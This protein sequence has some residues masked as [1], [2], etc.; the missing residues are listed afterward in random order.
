M[1]PDISAAEL[2]MRRYCAPSIVDMFDS[3]K[4]A[5][6]KE[7]LLLAL[8]TTQRDILLER[9]MDNTRGNGILTR[10]AGA[11]QLP[12]ETR[13][14]KS[15]PLVRAFLEM[16][17][18]AKLLCDE[19]NLDVCR[20][21]MSCWGV[22]S[23]T[24]QQ[25]NERVLW[26]K[27]SCLRSSNRTD[28]IALSRTNNTVIKRGSALP[29]W[30][31]LRRIGVS[32][33][34]LFA[35]AKECYLEGE[36][37]GEAIL[38]VLGGTVLIQDSDGGLVVVHFYNVLPAGIRGMEADPLLKAKF[39]MGASMRVAEPFLK[40]LREGSIG[41]RVDDPS[42][43]AVLP[44]NKLSL[45][46][47][48]AQLIGLKERGK[49]FFAAKKFDAAIDMY[50]AA[51]RE[52]GD[53]IPT[54]LSNRSQAFIRLEHWSS[55]LC[56]AAAS[57]T[58]RPSCKKTFARYRLARANLTEDGFRGH[59]AFGKLIG[60]VLT[61]T[62]S[63]DALVDR[64]N[65]NALKQAGNTAFQ[66][67]DFAGAIEL[68]GK[69]LVAIGGIVADVLSNWAVCA[70]Q[71][72]CLL[73]AVAASS[74]S[75]RVNV[76]DKPLYL[77]AK[78]LSLLGE[79]N[80]S[81]RIA[82]LSDTSSALRKLQAEVIEVQSL[83]SRT[84]GKLEVHHFPRGKLPPYLINWI[85]PVETF[86]TVSRGRGLRATGDIVSGQ[87]LLIQQPIVSVE[88]SL[89]KDK[90]IVTSTSHNV[91]DDPSLY[92]L[93]ATLV[94]RSQR[95][96]VLNQI[97]GKLSDGTKGKTLVPLRDLML[98]LDLCPL[99]LP[100][101][102]EYQ[103][104]SNSRLTSDVIHKVVD[105]NIHGAGDKIGA[106]YARLIPMVAMMNHAGSPNATFFTAPST[107]SETVAI[108]VACR[109]IERGE[110]ICLQYHYDRTVLLQ[111]WGI[112]D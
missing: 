22:Q 38:P 76:S 14:E 5:E 102:H 105:I 64:I 59:E 10:T 75:L 27:F 110:E 17:V 37:V 85:G 20:Q 95:D 90:S 81:V 87:I 19:A 49:S 100:V 104:S 15:C 101:H 103:D 4:T 42:D 79:Y 74:A 99:L 24:V 26:H 89:E 70:L 12:G 92:K 9:V 69:C 36:I 40:I 94:Q 11:R 83:I 8:M 32:E 71:T 56:D 111:K 43:I 80:S 77:L 112:S 106:S 13:R 47:T 48:D 73:D 23:I 2:A 30:K 65:E 57:L 88:T 46:N 55:A 52:S 35:T 68:Y 45:R 82:R 67:G 1:A 25:Y 86:L 78:A 6:Q 53:F 60:E 3:F 51:V 39:P 63:S 29:D 41:V 91:V 33:L 18:Q 61:S 34:D 50:V 58:I 28:E 96:S 54:V 108:V 44:R 98:N 21:N 97:L 109:N 93:K 31:K 84:N 62:R 7:T 72:G 107:K 16:G 66:R